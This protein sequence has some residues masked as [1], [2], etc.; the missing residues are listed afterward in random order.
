MKIRIRR[1]AEK[2]KAALFTMSML[3]VFNFNYGQCVANFSVVYGLNGNVSFSNTSTGLNPNP[4]Q[5][6][7]SWNYGDPLSANNASSNFNGAHYY[8]SNGVYNVTLT[9]QTY[10]PYCTHTIV[11][12]IT[13]TNSPCNMPIDAAY[14]STVDAV[15]SASFTSISTGTTAAAFYSWNF[16]DGNNGNGTNPLHTYTNAGYYPVT[17]IVS[18][19]FCVDTAL[20]YVLVTVP[21][22]LTANFSVTY[23][24]NGSVSFS[25]TSTGLNANAWQNGFQWTYGEPIS[26]FY[27]TSYN[28]NGSHQYGSNGVYNVTLTVQTMSPNCNS[29]VVQ[30]ITVT[31]SPCNMPIDA[32]YSYTTGA[33]GTAS[34]T[35]LCTGTTAAANYFWNFG[36]GNTAAGPNPV[37]TFTTN[38][39]WPVKLMVFDG[40]CIDS[41]TQ[42]VNTLNSPC[43]L[44]AGFTFTQGA[45]GQVFFSSSSTGTSAS[46]SFTWNFG[47]G[48][49]SN[50]NQGS[51]SY[52]ANGNYTVTLGVAN[53]CNSCTP[54]SDTFTAV[55]TVT[56]VT[57]NISA[58]FNYTVGAGGQ[59]NFAST[60]SGTLASA[61][62]SWDYG[63]GTTGT[64]ATSAHTYS[65]GG[66]H[67]VY[68]SVNNDPTCSDTALQNIN[69]SGIPCVANSNF[70]L[71]YSGVPQYWNAYPS[72][73]GN[74]VSA[75][76]YW[77]DGS[78]DTALYASHTYSAAGFYNICLSVTVSC[79]QT[80]STCASYSIYKTS[81]FDLSQALVHINVVPNYLTGI[82]KNTEPSEKAEIYPNPNDGNLTVKINEL[83]SKSQNASIN[84]FDVHGKL[85]Y[86]GVVEAADGAIE[87]QLKLDHLSEGVYYLKIKTLN[88][89]FNSKVMIQ[90]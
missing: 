50:G 80:S 3:F 21:C 23:G 57:C 67:Q 18:D 7:Y 74:V 9:I 44:I 35:S 20:Q 36:D 11:Q 61:T 77:G 5:N 76:W 43:L 58:G 29:F 25:N 4:W 56:S 89:T 41:L 70:S 83:G 2:W 10:S 55:V 28:S 64:G 48:A 26:G 40:G 79:A 16:G 37:H 62:Y 6:M 22:S 13:V 84:V 27:N 42:G 81:Q 46:T 38:N 47:N 15:G 85:V 12:T 86:S 60:S 71:M 8:N 49:F 59:V 88:K 39:Y 19:G 51:T 45:S 82:S 34:F 53:N 69:V 1:V 87:A 17:L 75:I 30:T 90:K 68:L 31:N 65:N 66:V 72:Y 78:S 73:F 32:N 14:T 54:C 52:V 33:A 63:D 24:P